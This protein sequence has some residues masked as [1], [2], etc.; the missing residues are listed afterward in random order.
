MSTLQKE[1]VAFSRLL[2]MLLNRAT[3]YHSSHPSVTTTL[4]DFYSSIGQVLKSISPL[5]FLVNRD[6][7]FIDEEPMPPGP[8]GS[9][10]ASYFNKTGIQSISFDS[11]LDKNEVKTFLD[12]LTSSDIYPN[13]DAMRK[14]LVT[15]GVKHVQIN[16][17]FFK[18]VT[19][20]DE[21]ISREA[22]KELTPKI[23]D[24]DEKESKKLFIDMVLERLL[25]E[26]LKET[27]TIENLLKDPAA[28]SNK[29]TE[30][31]VA[32]NNSGE[33]KTGHSGLVL[34]HQLEIL[35]ENLEKQLEDKA[36]L[37]EIARALSEMKQRLVQYMEAQKALKVNYS[38]EKMILEKVDEITDCVILRIVADEYKSGETPVLRL[39]QILR[40]L[41]PEAAELKRLLPKIRSTLLEKG[42]ALSEYLHLVQE[43]GNELQ[44]EGLAGI[45]KESSEEIG[46]DGEILIEEIKKNPAQAVELIYLAAEIQKGSGDERALSDLLVDYVERVGS[47]LTTDFEK[48]GKPEGEQRLRQVLTSIES[49]IVGRL[50]GLDIKDDL[51]ERLEEKLSSRIDGI[52][53]RIKLDW[54]HSH[55]DKA[56][57]T[58][59]QLSVLELLEQTVVD[60]DE[61]GEILEIIREKV[62]A[63]EIDKD[64]FAQIYAEITKQ[65]ACNTK[66]MTDRMP[67]DV[68]AEPAIS[69]LVSKEIAKARRYNTLFSAVAFSLVKAKAKQPGNPVKISYRKLL[70]AVFQ[71]V[72]NVV[73]ESDIVGQLGKNRIVVILPMT[74][75]S[76]AQLALRRFLKSF[77][78][79]TVTVD[80]TAI[81]IRLA[82]VA[83]AWDFI[84]TPDADSFIVTLTNELAQMER[85]IKNLQAYM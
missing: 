6:Q 74:P 42:M 19:L 83:V 24:H 34:M 28:L 13:A 26:E 18:K 7:F 71:A 57:D 47:R 1:L 69:V 46:I 40:R 29:M 38:N 35:G 5:V 2:V 62:Q 68:L 77:H 59:P 72:S 17:V 76:N 55:A 48:D 39:A 49:G 37:P 61:L 41:V 20:D 63:G 44:S 15:R 79:G 54:I 8:Q 10:I 14:A 52:L 11:G 30:T 33:L 53:E 21:V 65:Q 56:K 12:V 27:L 22:L 75:L 23:A 31:D 73:R 60:G 84:R 64:N 78:A 36:N 67:K 51:L 85:R 66:E 82:G 32:I 9:R 43:L 81:E 58:R 25:A 16:H 50:K 80:E 45:L 4:D 70:A 3:I